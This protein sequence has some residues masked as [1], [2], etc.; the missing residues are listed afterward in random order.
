MITDETTQVTPLL[1]H[2]CVVVVLESSRISLYAAV[3]RSSRLVLGQNN[4]RPE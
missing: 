1:A 4:K 3:L 2:D